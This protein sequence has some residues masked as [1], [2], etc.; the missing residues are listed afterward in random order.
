M[1]TV[2]RL[3]FLKGGAA[4]SQFIGRSPGKTIGLKK[5]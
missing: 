1:K 5:C 4:T 3:D 2:G